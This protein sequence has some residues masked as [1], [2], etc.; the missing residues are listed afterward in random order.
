MATIRL[1]N[2][3]RFK[4]TD[5]KLQSKLN[6]RITIITFNVVLLSVLTTDF[7]FDLRSISL[8]SIG[9]FLGITLLIL[10][11]ELKNYRSF[12]WKH[13]LIFTLYLLVESHIFFHPTTTHV[14]M[15]WLCA[16]PLAALLIQGFKSSSIWFVIIFLSIIGNYFYASDPIGNLYTITVHRA[17]YTILGLIF[18][19][20]IMTSSYLLYAL[21]DVAYKSMKQRAHELLALKKEV[22][23]SRAKLEKYQHALLSITKDHTLN[24]LEN[25][26][27]TICYKAAQNLQVSRASIWFFE[28]NNTKLT[29]YFLHDISGDDLEKISICR[30]HFPIYFT[31]LETQ[32]Y[33]KADDTRNHP[34]TQEFQENH[35][36]HP[37]AISMLDCPIIIDSQPFGAICCE[38][39]N[40]HHVWSTEDSLFIQSMADLIAISY[41]NESIKTLLTKIQLQNHELTEQSKEIEL[42]NRELILLNEELLT[43]NETLEDMVRQRTL[44]LEVQNKQLTEYAFINSHVLRAP[45]SRILGLSYLISDEVSVKDKHLVNALISS[46]RELDAII[47][48]IAELLYDG[49][50][51]SRE[52]IK[53]IIDRNLN[54]IG[55]EHS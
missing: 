18:L 26:F 53:I 3:K 33:I 14:L 27:E 43:I 34:H 30:K 15:F 39:R 41:K 35:P 10:Y 46:S 21:L 12:I 9:P 31:A 40:G 4:F 24:N 48:K 22:E 38:Q 29:R 45:L 13:V 54:K 2:N 52:D 19:A 20:G 36:D 50:N 28:N 44:E 47:N 7:F 16:V 5:H 37:G 42:M 8:L 51:L 55:Q 49:N 23:T 17:P 25:L 32:P 6:Y 1:P 11:I